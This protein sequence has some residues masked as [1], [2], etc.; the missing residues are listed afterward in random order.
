MTMANVAREALKA[1]KCNMPLADYEK[2]QRQDEEARLRE[3]KTAALPE[4]KE[5]KSLVRNPRLRLVVGG[6]AAW[7]KR[8]LKELKKKKKRFRIQKTRKA[9][10]S[11]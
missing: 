9:S 6:I 1:A 7:A 4:S 3:S 10:R 5:D 2:A 8:E 11:R